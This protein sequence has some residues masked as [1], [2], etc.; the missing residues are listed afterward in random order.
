MMGRTVTIVA[1]LRAL[2]LFNEK[3]DKLE[4]SSFTRK[5]LTERSGVE[6][7]AKRVETGVAVTATRF[8][9]DQESIDAF[10]LT[11]RFFVQDNEPSSFR[12]MADF[13]S[14]AGLPL[15][16][17]TTR[18]FNEARD[19]VNAYLDEASFVQVDNR[20]LTHREIFDVFMWG[21]LAHAY[22][23]KGRKETFDL[24][25]SILGFF[26]ILENEF[27]LALAT[28]LKAIFYIRELNKQAIQK[29]ETSSPKP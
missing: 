10:V 21:G 13:Y 14:D 15:D 5:I 7:S 29:L 9:P 18:R 3:A 12:N 17:E 26:Q 25:K 11:F 2:R 22:A 20:P 24:W 27:V 28:I 1:A 16:S 4:A 8:G 19:A 6:I 23:Q